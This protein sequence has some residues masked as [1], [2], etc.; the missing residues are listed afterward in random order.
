MQEVSFFDIE[1]GEKLLFKKSSLDAIETSQI[2][3]K[4]AFHTQ[5]KN[6]KIKNRQ[7]ILTKENLFLIKVPFSN[8]IFSVSRYI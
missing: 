5:K 6:R 7:L 4:N 2:L 8:E 1:E 3:L